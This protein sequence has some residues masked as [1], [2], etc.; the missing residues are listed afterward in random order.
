MTISIPPIKAFVENK[1][2]YDMEDKQGLSACHIIGIS[3]YK[4]QSITFT[5]LIETAY[6]FSDI[7]PFALHQKQ[8]AFTQELSYR[9]ISH[10]NCPGNKIEVICLDE[11]KSKTSIAFFREEHKW[12]EVKEYLYTIDFY[13]DNHLVHLVKLN[14][15]HFVLVPSHK[16]NFAGAKHLPDF[17]K[18]R[19]TW[20]I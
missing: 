8:S 5:I 13:E 15:G 6:I 18:L 11:L 4:G 9:S 3:A 19:Q 2:L 1:Y 7:P 16:I 12:I 20:I 14:T 10:S 17:K